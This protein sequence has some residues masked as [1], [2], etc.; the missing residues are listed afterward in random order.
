M[1][2]VGFF[3]YETVA[4]SCTGTPIHGSVTGLAPTPLHGSESSSESSPSDV[5]LGVFRRPDCVMA[6]GGGGD[7]CIFRCSSTTGTIIG[8]SSAA[9]GWKDQLSKQWFRH[10]DHKVKFVGIVFQ[11][12]LQKRWRLLPAIADPHPSIVVGVPARFPSCSGPIV[13]CLVDS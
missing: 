4:V 6:G 3:F 2:Q 10:G 1:T 8:P 7:L 5:P 9:V 13:A 11:K 12:E